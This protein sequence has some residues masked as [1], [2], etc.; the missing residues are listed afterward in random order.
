MNIGRRL[1]SAVAVLGVVIHTLACVGAAEDETWVAT[2]AAAQHGPY[3][4]GIAAAGPDLGFAFPDPTEGAV[5]QT[6]RLIVKP[7]LW[8]NRI[9]LRNSFYTRRDIR[10]L[11]QRQVFLAVTCTDLAHDDQAGVNANAHR[12]KNAFL[13]L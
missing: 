9:R 10:R 12:Q 3:P 4:S 5:D 1:V 2:W 6:I 7:D 11:S 13:L 8:G